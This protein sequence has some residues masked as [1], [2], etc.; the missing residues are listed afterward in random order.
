M[1]YSDLLDNKPV[2]CTYSWMSVIFSLHYSAK[3]PR[4]LLIGSEFG[5][6]ENIGYY[7]AYPN[8]LI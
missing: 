3:Q 6:S 8:L 7:K 4:Q 1:W 5:R 2:M